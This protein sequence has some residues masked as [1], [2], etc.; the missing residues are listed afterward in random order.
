MAASSP[1]CGPWPLSRLTLVKA[2][3][4]Q[5][6][7]GRGGLSTSVLVWGRAFTVSV[8]EREN[9]PVIQLRSDTINHPHTLTPSHPH[10]WMVMM[11]CT[12][13]VGMKYWYQQG[14]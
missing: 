6:V 10:R 4:S 14:K 11:M 7:A 5:R 12:E 1:L 13:L 2:L 9:V 8:L 3:W